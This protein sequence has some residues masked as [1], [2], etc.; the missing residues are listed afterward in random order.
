MFYFYELMFV[1]ETL[2]KYIYM[3]SYFE[4]FIIRN[5]MVQSKFNLDTRFSSYNLFS[6]YHTQ[7]NEMKKVICT[8]VPHFLRA[9]PRSAHCSLVGARQEP[10]NWA[11]IIRRE[12]M[13][14]GCYHLIR[15]TLALPV[16]S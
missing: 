12:K 11:G 4:V 13:A 8:S 5:I 9:Y 6:L 7:I 16:I 3:G 15:R 10:T 1:N 14:D 2:S